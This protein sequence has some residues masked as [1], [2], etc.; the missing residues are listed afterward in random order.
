LLREEISTLRDVRGAE[1]AKEAKGVK[2]AKEVKVA[3]EAAREAALVH[4]A[5]VPMAVEM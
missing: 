3:K 2:A 1:E 4:K 5:M